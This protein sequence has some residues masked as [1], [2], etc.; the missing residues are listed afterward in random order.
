MSPNTDKMPRFGFAQLR[1]VIAA[2]LLL[3]A[4]LKG[5]RLETSDRRRERYGVLRVL[6]R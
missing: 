3:A 6:R 1:F 2:V 5:V 4:G